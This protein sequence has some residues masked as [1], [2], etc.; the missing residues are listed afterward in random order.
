M[1]YNLID[2]ISYWYQF[3]KSASNLQFINNNRIT[4]L[5]L[6]KIQ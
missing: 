2:F 1:K 3:P 6:K 4:N 5:Q